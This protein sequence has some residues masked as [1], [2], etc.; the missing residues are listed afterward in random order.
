MKRLQQYK[1]NEFLNIP[2][3]KIFTNFGTV[4]QDVVE[5]HVYSDTNL[6]ASNHN[7]DNW[8][9]DQ[10]DKE[11]V[12]KEEP[13]IQLDIHEHVRSLGFA[14][15]KFLVK[16]NFYRNILGSYEKNDGLYVA[17]IS[18]TRL[19]IRLETTSGEKDILEL[20][21][22]LVVKDTSKF[23]DGH[24][25]D[26]Q[27]NLGDDKTILVVNWG[28]GKGGSV[29]FKLYEP[30]P[31]DILV[32]QQLW[33]NKTVVTSHTEE[34]K[35]IKPKPAPLGFPI[36]SP[37]W[38]TPVNKQTNGDSE[39]ETW[40]SILGDNLS[41]ADLLLNKVLKKDGTS[42]ELNIDYTDYSNFVHFGSA[43]E[44]L[45][46]F[47]YKK[48]LLE[49]YENKISKVKGITASG[50]ITL[51][52]TVK[53]NAKLNELIISFDG[54]EKYLY[55]TSASDAWPKTSAVYPYTL[56]TVAN[57]ANWFV[58]QSLAAIKYDLNNGD[59][60][61]KTVPR[62][63][64]NDP[65][66]E[67]YIL[68][69]A[70]A[71][72]HFDK[73]WSYVKHSSNIY[74]RDNGLYEGLSKDLIHS[75][76]G[77]LGWQS[78]QGFQASDIWE[79]MLGTNASGSYGQAST[80]TGPSG[81]IE[82][83]YATPEQQQYP[84]TT[85]DIVTENWKRILNNLPYLLKTKGTDR[86]IKALLTTYGLPSTLLR[87]FEYGGPEKDKTKTSYANFDKF[88]H[89]LDFKNGGRVKLPWKDLLST[90]PLVTTSRHADMIE[91][92]FNTTNKVSQSLLNTD[93]GRFNVE[94]APHPSASNLDSGYYNHGT[95]NFWVKDSPGGGAVTVNLHTG[96]KYLPLYDDDWWN[97]SIVRE[98]PKVDH[99]PDVDGLTINVAKA[100][101]HSKGRITHTSSLRVPIYGWNFNWDNVGDE[102]IYVGGKAWT[103]PVYGNSFIGSIQEVRYWAFPENQAV[104]TKWLDNE[105]FHNH[106]KN[107]LSIEG[108]GATGS[109]DQLVARYSLGADM[110]KFSGSWT[111][112]NMSTAF[113]SSSHPSF[114][115][116]SSWQTGISGEG[117]PINFAGDGTDWTN[118]DEKYFVAMP[119]AI[120]SREIG[121]K[122]RIAPSAVPSVLSPDYKLY[123]KDTE[124][125]D[126]NKI[127]VYFAPHFEIDIDIANDLGGSAVDDYMG[128]P[129][130]I[131]K[132][133]YAGLRALR[134]HYWKK[135]SAP[136]SFFDYMNVLKQLDHTMFKQ[137]ETMLPARANAQVGLLIK[138][139]MLD[140][141]KIKSL[142]VI[143]VDAS[144]Q[145]S[146]RQSSDVF[147]TLSLR[148][149]H[150]KSTMTTVGGDYFKPIKDGKIDY[151]LHPG[152]EG[153]GPQ[154]VHMNYLANNTDQAVG[155]LNIP[156]N[157]RK[158]YGNYDFKKGS[159]YKWETV[160]YWR[161]GNVGGRTKSH[162]QQGGASYENNEDFLVNVQSAGYMGNPD[163]VFYGGGPS[164]SVDLSA[165]SGSVLTRPSGEIVPSFNDFGNIPYYHHARTSRKYSTFKY[166][167]KSDQQNVPN[168]NVTIHTTSFAENG[169]PSGSVIYTS[170]SGPVRKTIVPAQLQDNRSIGSENR[171]YRGCKL[172]GSDFNMPLTA[173][174]DGGPVV[175][176]NEV[177][178]VNLIVGGDG[179]SSTGGTM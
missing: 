76:L 27:L 62:H 121:D 106:V 123:K 89:A 2:S 10:F 99:D 67:N 78:F 100:A 28:V 70:M 72:Q 129:L 26:L 163:A 122:I 116:A 25:Q 112:G 131:G 34:I 82:Y 171:S 147:A 170:I 59:N 69:V 133:S 18:A 149:V 86:N 138:G 83:V 47:K 63:I 150:F 79:Y 151:D 73:L 148:R 38:D 53:Y 3:K 165:R 58:T 80:S 137:I 157:T 120:G 75:T 143:N 124:I 160:N 16:Y 178:P 109:Y 142:K 46:N 102:Y 1:I 177:A 50:S 51:T 60:L 176:F 179:F 140:R 153:S 52:D 12:A 93:N 13:R 158:S 107:P 55:N 15:G 162:V 68:F 56:D 88:S 32:K 110:N 145:N 130:D 5:C 136:Y 36:Q 40:D 42:T 95:I 127:G 118:E 54:Y 104:H 4:D 174:V 37:D 114:Y 20:I 44:R 64:V 92:R 168:E 173:T 23:I 97:V 71:G 164:S 49:H 65:N 144:D 11:G 6:L 126:L 8:K 29:I 90:H 159:R 19:E 17:E 113:M 101:D 39:Y 14:E 155:F 45:E 111:A 161:Q 167:Y 21:D 128:N 108:F 66:N 22:S 152:M 57:S 98:I 87:V 41:S 105:Y 103:Q 81:S 175:E 84:I 156:L 85:E 146:P 96:S 154:Q 134:Q 48:Q 91:L 43:N 141:P 132:G 169:W 172:I 9:M 135:H 35:L 33:I 74:N 7:I 94:I 30:L 77:S 139:N 117:I 24:W 125:L 31:K 166:H 115:E 119:G 61:E